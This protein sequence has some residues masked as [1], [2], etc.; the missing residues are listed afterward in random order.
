MKNKVF[1]LL[2]VLG[3]L[4]IG[5]NAFTAGDLLVN[6]EIGLGPG[7]L[8]NVTSSGTGRFTIRHEVEFEHPR[9][10]MNNWMGANP[11]IFEMKYDQE[12]GGRL[13]TIPGGMFE[14]W[15]FADAASGRNRAFKICGYPSAALSNE[16]VSLKIDGANNDLNMSTEGASSDI[17]LMP[18]ANVGIGTASPVYPLEM[19]SGAYVT[20]GGVW[21]D[22][23]SREFKENITR[24][25]SN[26]AVETLNNLDP[27]KFNYKADKEE[28]YVGFIAED[29]P[30]MVAM[31]DRT[32]LSPMDI[33]AVLTKVTQDQQKTISEL[34]E[35]LNKLEREMKLKDTLASIAK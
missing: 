3:L 17:L 27:V 12:P 25:S 13:D 35:R 31:K 11:I 20:T 30:E 5:V 8:V 28:S 1:I 24:L 18:Q 9:F 2:L 22:A 6:G 15:L 32:G 10:T 23:S 26:E 21:T 4:I 34:T 7:G 33:V 14:Y 19:A 16:C 29:V